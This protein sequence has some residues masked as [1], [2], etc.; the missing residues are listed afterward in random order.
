MAGFYGWRQPSEDAGLFESFRRW[1]QGA[2]PDER[3]EF[4]QYVL[5]FLTP[6]DP[7][8]EECQQLLAPRDPQKPEE[9]QSQGGTERV[10]SAD[11]A[12]EREWNWI[13]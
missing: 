12:P 10:S 8:F 9:P 6:S 4:C 13:A 2:S 1:W 5:P 7:G 11:E 3:Q